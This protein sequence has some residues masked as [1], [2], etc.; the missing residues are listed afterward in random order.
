MKSQFL[1]LTVA[2]IAVTAMQTASAQLNIGASNATRAAVHATASTTAATRAARQTTTA[3][4]TVAKG[5][6]SATVT[7]AQDVR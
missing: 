1:R 7:K 5:T 2:A 6:T 4:T 3:A